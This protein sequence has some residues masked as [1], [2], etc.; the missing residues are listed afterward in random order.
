VASLRQRSLGQTGHDQEL[1]AEREGLLRG[2]QDTL[3]RIAALKESIA[4]LREEA[5][6]GQAQAGALAAMREDLQ[7]KTE[8]LRRE[9]RLQ[10]QKKEKLSGDLA[11]QEERRSLARQALDSAAAKLYEDYEITPREAEA[12][13]FTLSDPTGAAMEVGEVTAKIRA[14][15]NINV[16]AIEEYKE[17]AERYAFLGEQI[18]DIEQS[19]AEL[20]RLIAELTEKMSERF[21]EHFAKINRYFGET[22]SELFSGGQAA[23]ELENPLDLLESAIEIRVQPPGKNVQNID[24]LSGGEKGL[25]AIAL[26]FAILKATP[27]PFCIFDEVEAALD[28]INVARYARYVRR[29]TKNTQFILIS[30]RRGTM[31]EADVLYGVTMQEEGVSKLLEMKTKEMAGRLG[32]E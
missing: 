29:M 8:T 6:R 5:S 31:E 12:Q 2:N 7:A 10:L 22:F 1:L 13:G 23:L 24:L 9:E 11:R 4:G 3:G 32:I 26:L 19:K 15:G 20:T 28:D 25:S 27:A 16:D 30:H 17:V 14:L 21:R 18:G